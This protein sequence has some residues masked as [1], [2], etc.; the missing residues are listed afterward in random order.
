MAVPRYITRLRYLVAT[1]YAPLWNDI[2]DLSD[3]GHPSNVMPLGLLAF[4]VRVTTALSVSDESVHIR[5]V[6][7][8]PFLTKAFIAT[9]NLSSLSLKD[10]KPVIRMRVRN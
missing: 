2:G 6:Q 4:G 10:V 8:V 3:S 5:S 1:K 7:G 9:F